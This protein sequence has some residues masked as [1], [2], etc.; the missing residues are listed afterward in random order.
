MEFILDFTSLPQR[1]KY[2]HLSKILSEIKSSTHYKGELID[3]D[4]LRQLKE[5]DIEALLSTISDELKKDGI[6]KIIINNQS[7]KSID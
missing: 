5:D 6:T 1:K 7:L 4:E 2:M 3:N